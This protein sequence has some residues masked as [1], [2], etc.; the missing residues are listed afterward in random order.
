MLL[1][2]KTLGPV[3]VCRE[4]K[5]AYPQKAVNPA[6]NK[7]Y[8]SRELDW[9]LSAV[10]QLNLGLPLPIAIPLQQSQRIFSPTNT[11]SLTE[12]LN[13]IEAFPAMGFQSE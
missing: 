10:S 11:K 4:R 7:L 8:Q 12:S 5:R 1:L 2:L 3:N 13:F 9:L 6:G